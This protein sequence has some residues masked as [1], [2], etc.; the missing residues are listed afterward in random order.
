MIGTEAIIKQKHN[1]V[2]NI[3]LQSKFVPP[4]YNKVVIEFS[5]KYIAIAW[6][7]SLQY[8]ASSIT[9]LQQQQHIENIDRCRELWLN[10][11]VKHCTNQR[12][13]SNLTN[14]KLIQSKN[15]ISNKSLVIPCSYKCSSCI[16]FVWRH[17]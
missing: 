8:F 6:G 10:L 14:Q 11:N 1:N 4:T 16:P 15:I 5:M 9:D 2:S 13:F 17:I 7:Y 12:T 3:M